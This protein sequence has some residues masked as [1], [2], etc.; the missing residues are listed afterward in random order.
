MKTEDFRQYNEFLHG[1]DNKDLSLEE[2]EK[3]RK[4]IQELSP[5]FQEENPKKPGRGVYNAAFIPPIPKKEAKMESAGANPETEKNKLALEMAIY[6]IKNSGNWVN[7][8][9]RNE[10]VDASR[11]ISELPEI[12]EEL[13]RK[14]KEELDQ[15]KG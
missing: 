12:F 10:G 7:H 14:K 3:L 13:L 11:P 6:N 8:L 5:D 4:E 15:L 1:K 9:L 2:Q